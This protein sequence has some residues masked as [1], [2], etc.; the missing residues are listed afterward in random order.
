[1]KL[2][3]AQQKREDQCANLDLELMHITVTPYNPGCGY[4][5]R[6]WESHDATHPVIGSAYVGRGT[7]NLSAIQDLFNRYV[8]G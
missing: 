5:K 8:I 4:E 6:Y 2:T 3:Q 1:M 7:D